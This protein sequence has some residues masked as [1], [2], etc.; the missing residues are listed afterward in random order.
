M[1]LPKA[2]ADIVDVL[3]KE[4]PTKP[5]QIV[6]I[7]KNSAVTAADLLPYADFEHSG[8]DSYGRK[9]VYKG[10]NYEIMVMSWNKGDFSAIHDHGH[11][12]WGA[13][14][15][16]GKAEHATFRW[17]DEHL[18]TLARWVVN[19]GDVLGV[20]HSLIHQMGNC[21][22]EPFVSLH[23]YGHKDPQENITGEARIFDLH[24]KQIQRVNGGAFLNLGD[25]E[26][27]K[28]QEGPSADFP[29]ELRFHLESYKRKL[30][31]SDPSADAYY[32]VVFDPVFTSSLIRHLAEIT[33]PDTQLVNNSIQWRILKRELRE[34][35]QVQALHDQSEHSTDTF[36][37]YAEVYD[38]II[39]H[40]C[41]DSFMEQYIDFFSRKY[42][43]DFQEKKTLSIGCGTGLV[44]QRIIERY[45]LKA[46]QLYGI[47]I[48]ESMI[49]EARK[50][51]NADVG[52]LLTL[53]PN[54][55]KWDLAYSGLNVF[56]YLP[57][58]RLEEAIRRTADILHDGGY[59]LGDFIT[60]D[61]IRWYPNV[62]L[63]P[64]QQVISL[65]T[66]LLIEENGASFQESEIININTLEGKIHVHYAGKHKR[67]LAP[68]FRIRSYFEKYFKGSVD[69]YDAVALKPIQPSDDS[70]VSTRYIVVARK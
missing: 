63:G 38:R 17:E 3:E 15:I 39:G 37:K 52:D 11:T 45:H 30:K 53:D 70:C 54:V 21:D 5:S 57:H 49:H 31:A 33:D 59:F 68:V 27:V 62:I 36:H 8:K 4:Q 7:V 1:N 23:I 28:K 43:I 16:F 18:S 64:E 58:D 69:L 42:A 2:L 51:I 40:S 12:M 55:R 61:H 19:A 50:R 25:S 22:Q 41:L 29:T 67:F 65:R 56:Q 14:K 48:S 6:S 35:A 44:E 60:P 24:N 26:I 9:M 66:P 46:D 13:V 32:D 20:G 47:D 34:A 10:A